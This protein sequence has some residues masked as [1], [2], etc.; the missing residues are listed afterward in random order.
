MTE[1]IACA[2]ECDFGIWPKSVMVASAQRTEQSKSP[3]DLEFRVKTSVNDWLKNTP[4]GRV[5]YQA[6]SQGFN[7]G[8]LL[9]HLGEPSLGVHL[10]LPVPQSAC[11]GMPC[12]VKSLSNLLSAFR[13]TAYFTF[14]LPFAEREDSKHAND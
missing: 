4:E 2:I 11:A 6:S 14:C 1:R 12:R 5:A 3:T 13:S 7:A 8:D 9:Q 10:L